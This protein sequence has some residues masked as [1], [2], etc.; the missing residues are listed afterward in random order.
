MQAQNVA[1]TILLVTVAVLGTVVTIFALYDIISAA[2]TR[3]RNRELDEHVRTI[4]DDLAA[5]LPQ[6]DARTSRFKQTLD[7]Y[8]E[9]A[10]LDPRVQAGELTI[11]D[12]VDL[13]MLSE[14]EA[15]ALSARANAILAASSAT[16]E[17]PYGPHGPMC[18]CPPDGEPF[19]IERERLTEKMHAELSEALDDQR[20]DAS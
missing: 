16:P 12:I 11:D 20:P 15:R 14:D 10:L 17:R 5:S 1:T 8:D 6:Y 7:A 9:A 19:D 18:L 4:V 13:V 2:R 3:R